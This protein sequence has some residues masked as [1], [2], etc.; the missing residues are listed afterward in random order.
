MLFVGVFVPAS[1]IELIWAVGIGTAILIVFVVAIIMNVI[2]S[3]KNVI[4][5]Q[6]EKYSQ[7]QI[8]KKKYDDLFNNVRDIIYIHDLEGKI[9]HI[10]Q[11]VTRLLGYNV[12]EVIGKSIFDFLY[13]DSRRNIPEFL[14]GI[15]ERQASGLISLKSKNNNQRIFE[16]RNSPMYHDGMKVTVRGVA[17]DVT[18]QVQ[19]QRAL[20]KSELHFRQLLGQATAMRQ[21]FALLSQEV[22]RVQEEERKRISRELH[23][24]MGQLLTAINV[25]LEMM[26]KSIAKEE[27]MS[28]RR[29]DDIQ[30]LVQQVFESIHRFSREL[31]PILLDELGLAS[32]MRWYIKQFTERTGIQVV[33]ASNPTVEDLQSDQKAVLYRVFQE[34]LTNVLKHAQAQRV[35]ISFQTHDS[36][37]TMEIK[38][39]GKSFKVEAYTALHVGSKGLGILGMRERVH[40]MSG[41]LVI[42]SEEGI[43]TIVKVTIPVQSHTP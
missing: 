14:Y 42:H 12:E 21:N 5:L 36:F 15:I 26:R 27:P 8:S 34:S 18:Q 22:L 28:L 24:E 6:K 19:T 31:R 35:D 13:Y 11:S 16:Y 38:D 30:N 17:R 10:N 33:F 7:L 25:S 39:N 41:N 3:Q 32:A 4:R 1:S 29:I 23:D 2:V 9:L 37:V 40:S 20:R 43:G